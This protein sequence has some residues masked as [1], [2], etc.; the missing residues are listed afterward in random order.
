MKILL[1]SPLPPPV[2]G[3]ANWSKI[4]LAYYKD[5]SVNDIQIIHQDTSIKNR[6]ILNTGLVARL[7]SGVLDSHKI[8]RALKSNI[9][10]NRPDVIHLTS[11]ASL[12]LFKDHSIVKLANRYHIPLV[13]HFR[14][15]R[16]GDLS[17]KKNWEWRLLLKVMNKAAYSIV[18]DTKTVGILNEYNVNNVKFIPNPMS[19]ELEKIAGQKEIVSRNNTLFRIVF[20]GHMTKIKGIF[21]LVEACNRIENEIELI[22]IGPYK[23]ETK[24]HITKISL[25]KNKLQFKGILAKNEIYKELNS[26]DLMVLPSYTEGFPN[27]VVEAMAIG[28]PVVATDVGAI[29][30]MI[31]KNDNNECGICIPAKNI[32]KLKDAMD[33]MMNNPETSMKMAQKAKDKAFKQYTMK[34]I[35]SE[36]EQI[37]LGVK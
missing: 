17:R 5:K 25:K 31:D 34:H 24:E 16:I 27:V 2:G 15:G 23:E 1:L 10:Q 3:I 19:L 32:E 35:A 12:A 13:I 22:F 4:V 8:I 20:I 36:Y 14:F 37:W 28:C 11:S 33:Y 26:S 29:K 30:E 21:E 7:F 6:Q 9:K 18:L